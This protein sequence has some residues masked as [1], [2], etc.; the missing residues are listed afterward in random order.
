VAKNDRAEARIVQVGRESGGNVEILRGLQPG[1]RI[2]SG[3]VDGLADGSLI[4]VQEAK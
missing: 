1:E 4:A 2:V 3:Q